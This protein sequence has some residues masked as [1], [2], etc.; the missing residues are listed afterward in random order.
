MRNRVK[1]LKWVFLIEC[2]IL[3]LL[4][5]SKTIIS[6]GPEIGS[7]RINQYWAFIWLGAKFF[8]KAWQTIICGVF[9]SFLTTLIIY[10]VEYSDIKEQNIENFCLEVQKL[11]KKIGGLP[12]PSFRYSEKDMI[13]LLKELNSNEVMKMMPENKR[14]INEKNQKEFL[15]KYGYVDGIEKQSDM[16]NLHFK[17]MTKEIND[18]FERVFICFE[19]IDI[20]DLRN[21]YGKIC[22]I[23]RKGNKKKEE[24]LYNEI[25]V[26]ITEKYRYMNIFL[27]QIQPEKDGYGKT[28]LRLMMLEKYKKIVFEKNIELSK[29]GAQYYY[30]KLI[31]EWLGKTNKILS[32]L[33]KTEFP[34]LDKEY[35]H[36]SFTKE[37]LKRE[38]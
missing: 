7:D 38:Y 35:V 10:Y 19:G 26:D 32:D 33:H 22:F 9:G 20:E 15:S 5:C 31:Y 3:L 8:A 24:V 21:A 2:F 29:E 23:S 4:L 18:V 30:N 27:N 36:A 25:L 13:E 34:K 12:F 6:I 37:Y 28:L 1:V 17:F 14:V 16:V 11:V